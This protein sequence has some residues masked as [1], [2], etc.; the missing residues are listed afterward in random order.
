M[1]TAFLILCTLI[2]V[3]A[4]WSAW[5]EPRRV[6]IKRFEIKLEGLK[7][8]LRAVAIGDIQPNQFH[9]SQDRMTALFEGLQKQEN[10]DLVLWLGDYY[11]AHTDLSKKF[12]DDNPKL[13]S[14][15]DARMPT[16]DEIAHAMSHLQGRIGSFGVLG[17]HDWAWSGSEVR[18]ALEDISVVVLQD[19]VATANDPQNDQSIQIL[20]YED[21]SSGR[22]PKYSAVHEK[23]DPNL[24]QI[25]LSHS[26]DAFPESLG[27]PPLMLSGHTH[28]GQIRFPILGAMVLPIRYPEYDWGWFTER[29]RRLYVTSG[30]GTSLPPLRFMCSPE[31]IILDLVPA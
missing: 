17:N 29:H 6:V 30:L 5:I 25:G 16:M 23:L 3:L 21:I 14:W 22:I 26:P 27:G 28:G 19:E 1:L 15:I 24:P 20:G 12:L 4:V 18:K 9:W 2:L 7:A 8:P 31:V 11:N 10:P 13:K